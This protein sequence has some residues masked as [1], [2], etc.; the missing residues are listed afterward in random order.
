M[1]DNQTAYQLLV[2]LSR[3]SKA[4]A[5][6]L[7]AQVEIKNHWSG[8]GFELMGR[9][10]IASLAE[11]SEMLEVPEVTALPGVKA[12]VRGVSNVRG[13]LLPLFDM[14]VFFGGKLSAKRR[15]HRVLT[16]ESDDIFGGL[17][18][19]QVF[20]IQHFPVDSYSQL[21]TQDLGGAAAF[22]DGCYEADGVEWAVFSPLKLSQSSDFVN[23]AIA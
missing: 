1:A 5:A 18:V 10:Y 6:G 8:I 4:H 3:R 9:R 12:W 13:R 14:A 7:P 2:D 19:D 21:V 16:V 15:L 22:V 23:A 20:G 17:V 11:V